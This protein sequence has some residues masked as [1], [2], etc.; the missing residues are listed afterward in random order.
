MYHFD[1]QRPTD[2]AAAAAAVKGADARFLA[3]GQ[4]LIQAMKLRLSQSERLVDLG[5]I[6]D[7]KGIRLDGGNVVIG[8]MTPRCSCVNVMIS[9]SHDTNASS[10]ALDDSSSLALAAR[11]SKL[12]RSNASSRVSRVGKWRYSVPRPTSALR[13]TSRKDASAP[14]SAKTSRAIVSRWS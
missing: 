1:Y 14:C 5:G 2:R 9:C 11:A 3:G 10:D 13:A 4:T 6:A 7:L 12:E 8:A